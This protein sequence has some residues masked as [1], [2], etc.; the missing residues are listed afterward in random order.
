MVSLS[1]ELQREKKKITRVR[2][3]FFK[4]RICSPKTHFEPKHRKIAN[5]YSVMLIHAEKQEKSGQDRH[6]YIFQEQMRFWEHKACHFM[7]TWAS[8]CFL[9]PI[10]SNVT[11]VRTKT[12]YLGTFCG[13]SISFYLSQCTTD[14]IWNIRQTQSIT[15]FPDFPVWFMLIKI[16]SYLYVCFMQVF[17][18]CLMTNSSIHSL[19]FL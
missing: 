2:W 10:S 16:W 14:H 4:R 3:F 13:R 11:S 17:L 1:Q 9:M 19:Q 6:N 8:S 5:W 7:R 15:I 12:L 18:L